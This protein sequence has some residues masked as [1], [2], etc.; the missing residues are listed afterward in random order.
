MISQR[1]GSQFL[2]KRSVAVAPPLATNHFLLRPFI[3]NAFHRAYPL[4]IA[5]LH[6]LERL[7][8][9]LRSFHVLNIYLR[10]LCSV[11]PDFGAMKFISQTHSVSRR[12]RSVF[13]GPRTPRCSRKRDEE[14]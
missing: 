1:Y 10:T 2:T 7:S 8:Y 3:R 4:V 9:F 14:Q 13:E 12:R 6:V 11:R 5:Q